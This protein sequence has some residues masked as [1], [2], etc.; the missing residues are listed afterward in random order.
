MGSASSR[1]DDHGREKIQCRECGKWYHRLDVHLKSAH[2]MDV[3]SYNEKHPGAPTISDS[4]RKTAAKG[5]IKRAGGSAPSEPIPE[6]PEG[7][8]EEL[9]AFGVARLSLRKDLS[10][11]DQLFV[12]V[13]D[14][15]WKPGK[16]EQEALEAIALAIQEGDNVLI[17]GPAGIGKSTVARELAAIINQPLRYIPFNGE[18][19]VDD[20]VGGDQLLVDTTSGQSVT[21]YKDGPLIDAAEKGHWVLFDEFDS[22]PSHVGF[23]L[24]GCLE[25]DRKLTRSNGRPV[26]FERT[27]GVI[28]TANTLGLGDESGMYAGTAP[29]NR[30][31]LDRFAVIVHMD[32]PERDDE[33][34]IL[35]TKTGIDRDR[36]S[37]MVAVAGKVRESALQES[38]NADLSTRR[39]LMWA[40]MAVRMN[41]VHKS[42]KFT[43]L[44]R[45][46]PD[47]SKFVGGLVQRYFGS[48]R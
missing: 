44:N 39:L 8:D 35:V 24:H 23:I 25:K 26:K 13:H 7:I 14:E 41:D 18:M 15:G 42:A 4:A 5:Q 32:Y 21:E 34:S 1:F 16:Q 6:V 38:S 20:L 46:S 19:R 31:L 45:L 30:A 9:F 33:I 3:A 47:D 36:A 22:C 12:P 27:F 29:M 17:T 48:A 40:Q 11:S 28:A 43:V 37:K 10:E 2:G